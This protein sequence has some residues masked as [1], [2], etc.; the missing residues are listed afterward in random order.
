MSNVCEIEK[1]EEVDELQ[2]KGGKP[3]FMD[4]LQ[5]LNKLRMENIC[6]KADN[7]QLQIEKE[8]LINDKNE[9]HNMI[10]NQTD[11]KEFINNNSS[12]EYIDFLNND[13]IMDSYI[14]AYKNVE[15]D[16]EFAGQKFSIR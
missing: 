4:M 16:F 15:S 12:D 3:T 1:A 14:E 10:D 2:S 9:L 7:K 13:K 8:Q 11:K 6:L 5:E